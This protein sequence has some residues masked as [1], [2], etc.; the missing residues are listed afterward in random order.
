MHLKLKHMDISDTVKVYII[1]GLRDAVEELATVDRTNEAGR[2]A[3]VRIMS[4]HDCLRNLQ[5]HI[6]RAIQLEEDRKILL[7]TPEW[8]WSRN[9]TG[10]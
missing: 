5:E 6:D 4:K 8:H 9:L 2:R 7:A 10:R 3:W 1:C